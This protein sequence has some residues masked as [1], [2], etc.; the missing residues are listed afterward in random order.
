MAM[1][2]FA[3]S[4]AFGSMERQAEAS[5]ESDNRRVAEVDDNT[6]KV[7]KQHVKRQYALTYVN[8]PRIIAVFLLAVAVP[9]I[10]IYLYVG[11]L[12]NPAGHFHGVQIKIVNLDSGINITAIQTADALN[13]TGVGVLAQILPLTNIG[14]FLSHNI[15]FGATSANLF[16]WKYYDSTN[17]TYYSLS[18]VQNAVSEG[19]EDA[20][21]VYFIPADYTANFLVQG[22]NVH[23]LSQLNSDLITLTINGELPSPLN[24]SYVNPIY[25]VWDQG[26][27]YA[28]F[29]YISSALTP[30]FSGLNALA[31]NTIYA[32]I[33]G[34]PFGTEYY[35]A[36]F[37]LDPVPITSVNVHPI[38]WY[39]MNFFSYLAGLVLWIGGIVNMT[40]VVKFTAAVEQNFFRQVRRHLSPVFAMMLRVG[41]V[42][43]M[44][45]L[46]AACILSVIPALGGG[47]DVYYGKGK[48][49]LFLWYTALCFNFVLGS[50]VALLGPDLFQLPS[51]LWL[52]L[53]LTTSG[54]I[55]DP[56]LMN[57]FYD[58]GRAFPLFYAVRGN[59]TILFGSYYHI[60]E[61][62]LV[63]FGWAVGSLILIFIFGTQRME[64][65]WNVL[66]ESAVA[67]V[68]RDSV[69]F[70]AG[71]TQSSPVEMN[72]DYGAKRGHKV[73]EQEI[74]MSGEKER[75]ETPVTSQKAVIVPNGMSS[76]TAAAHAQNQSTQV[77]TQ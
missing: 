18:D 55:L 19:R 52:I 66:K 61:D 76:E 36:A 16:D 34:V 42:S 56:V 4:D 1:S 9:T 48:L 74:A 29:A 68:L 32:S 77:V 27:S 57:D 31:T 65:R 23:T 63:L 75:L 7:P 3:L 47:S 39:G 35:K 44:A 59:R 70:S 17:S 6:S 64:Q 51:T 60:E 28:T 30:L 15:V 5:A 45:M 43:M 12:W 37:L 2:A 54:G 25:Q 50:L 10:Y 20:W 22:I 41:L 13:A 11:A 33:S 69:G 46:Q 53:Q 14:L 40:I 21:Y 62:T 67:D 24:G 72:D 26:R 73:G 49:F 8:N 58:V 71:R 38:P